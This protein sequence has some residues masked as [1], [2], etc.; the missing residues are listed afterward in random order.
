MEITPDNLEKCGLNQNLAKVFTSQS[1]KLY[2]CYKYTRETVVKMIKDG[3]EIINVQNKK[4]YWL[5]S[6]ITHLM[7]SL[8]WNIN[9][10]AP[11][12]AFKESQFLI[13]RHYL[14]GIHVFSEDLL[15]C[16]NDLEQEVSW[17]EI[18]PIMEEIKEIMRFTK[19]YEYH[20]I[21]IELP[22]NVR[23]LNH[24]MYIIEAVNNKNE[25]YQL[26]VDIFK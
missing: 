19:S 18:K 1:L 3:S 16:I 6:P 22:G 12:H 24:V 13:P 10:I 20:K 9:K 17:Y 23:L 26:I 2:Q 8:V 25:E 15:N 11:L 5:K 4:Y 14:I 21:D 7:N